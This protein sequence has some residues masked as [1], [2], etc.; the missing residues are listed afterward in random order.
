MPG[1][2]AR[3]P[4][5]ILLDLNIRR[6]SGAVV[7]G[8]RRRGEDLV[9]NPKPDILMTENDVLIILGDDD[10]LDRFRKTYL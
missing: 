2:E 9:F 3:V 8:F 1:L 6:E 7:L 4:G 5:L 10:N